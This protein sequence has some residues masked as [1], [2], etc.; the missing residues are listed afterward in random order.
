MI[1]RKIASGTA[2]VTL[3]EAKTHLRVTSASEDA[4][5]TAM[6]AAACDAVSEFSGRALRSETWEMWADRLCGTVRLPKSPA[7]AL[8]AVYWLDDAGVSQSRDVAEF[9]LIADDDWALVE[10]RP[11]YDWPSPVLTRVDA[12]GLRFVAGYATLPPALR[13]AVLMMLAHLYRNREA[14]A[15]GASVEV[16][17]GVES[18]VG[19]HRLGWVA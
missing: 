8:S 11:G 5:I 10:P 6:I 1:L 16:P 4:L 15:G 9:T 2:P 18:L 13:A 12:V 7:T 17:M 3:E 19:I 14:V